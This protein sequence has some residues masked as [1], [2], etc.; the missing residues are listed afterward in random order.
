MQW[1]AAP[2]LRASCTG[3]SV[4]KKRGPP[5]DSVLGLHLFES[6][7]NDARD[8][9]GSSNPHR[10]HDIP[11]LVV[12]PLGRPQLTRRLRVFQLQ[13][14]FAGAGGFEEVDDVLSVEA[15]GE[16]FPG[17]GSL[18]RIFRLARFCRGS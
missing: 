3:P 2:R 11:V 18:D 4:R 15:D 9:D 14:Y 10:H 17:V 6:R 8:T 13:A 12:I 1:S 7:L 16:R 5:D